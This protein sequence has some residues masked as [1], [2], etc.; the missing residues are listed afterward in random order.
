MEYLMYILLNIQPKLYDL[1][2]FNV[3]YQNQIWIK[4]C[5]FITENKRTDRRTDTQTLPTSNVFINHFA[6]KTNTFQYT[7]RTDLI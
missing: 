5:K 2:S 7:H 4:V 6:L 3:D 1:R